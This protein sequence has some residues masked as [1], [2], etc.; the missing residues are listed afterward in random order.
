MLNNG[1][2]P[3]HGEMKGRDEHVVTSQRCLFCLSWAAP[4]TIAA[5][6]QARQQHDVTCVVSYALQMF[7]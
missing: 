7:A 2:E 4:A 1:G 5:L 6:V 3:T